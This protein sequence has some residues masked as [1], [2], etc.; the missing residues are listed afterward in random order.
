MKSTLRII[1]LC[2]VMNDRRRIPDFPLMRRHSGNLKIWGG[3]VWRRK[4]KGRET[5]GTLK[6][7]RVNEGQSSVTQSIANS[8]EHSARS[9]ILG[10]IQ[11]LTLTRYIHWRVLC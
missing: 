10:G 2:A 6:W 7:N 5:V 1:W 4:R 8:I 9:E 3:I 11:R